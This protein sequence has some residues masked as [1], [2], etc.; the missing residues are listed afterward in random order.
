MYLSRY[1]G[2]PPPQV[3]LHSFYQVHLSLRTE[4]LNQS[5][6]ATDNTISRS[7]GTFFRHKHNEVNVSVIF[8]CKLDWLVNKRWVNNLGFRSSKAWAFTVC[9]IYS[10]RSTEEI[11]HIIFSYRHCFT[12][13]SQRFLMAMALSISVIVP[14]MSTVYL[15]MYILWTNV[16]LWCWN[17]Y[18]NKKNCKLVGLSLRYSTQKMDDFVMKWKWFTEDFSNVGRHVVCEVKVFSSTSTTSERSTK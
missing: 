14:K 16:R 7:S 17:G 18:G 9:M 2:I 5:K 12:L 11:K 1:E 6:N 4:T 3:P 8:F 10:T 13:F 15:C